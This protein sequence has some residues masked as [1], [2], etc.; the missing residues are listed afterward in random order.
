MKGWDGNLYCELCVLSAHHNLCSLFRS[1]P[2]LGSTFPTDDVSELQYA[3]FK[4][5][6]AMFAMAVI[7]PI[8]AFA[9]GILVQRSIMA[10]LICYLLLLVG[11]LVASAFFLLVEWTSGFRWLHSNYPRSVTVHEGV[12]E[13]RNE[14]RHVRVPLNQM[15]WQIGRVSDSLD[16]WV[17]RDCKAIL[18]RSWQTFGNQVLTVGHTA[19]EFDVWRAFLMLAHIPAESSRKRR[20]QARRGCMIALVMSATLGCT[21]V[22][23]GWLSTTIAVA[24]LFLLYVSRVHIQEWINDGG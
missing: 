16:I 1:T 2:C 13:V 17:S 3:T 23:P 18:L 24:M 9:T 5:G 20:Q 19:E 6:R 21:I 10:G 14:R 22:F 8:P 4:Y 12:V 7:L 11:S 15:T